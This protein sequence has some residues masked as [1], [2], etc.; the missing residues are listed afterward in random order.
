MRHFILYLLAMLIAISLGLEIVLR[1]FDPIGLWHIAYDNQQLSQAAQATHEGYLIAQGR[2]ELMGGTTT[3]LTGGAR[4]TPATNPLAPCKIAFI[5]DSYTQGSGVDDSST[6]VNQLA[7]LNPTIHVVNVGRSAYNAAQIVA[8]YQG[9][10]ADG[11][12]YL[13]I[14]NDWYRP[15][16]YA[17]MTENSFH[18][19]VLMLYIDYLRPSSDTSYADYWAGISDNNA[20]YRAA[21]LELTSDERVLSFA[22]DD[23]KYGTKAGRE[24]ASIVMIPAYK[25]YRLS[26]IDEHPNAEG[27]RLIAEAMNP[28][29]AE[30]VARVCP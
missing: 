24:Y 30:F 26:T 22:L 16:T 18:H 10:Q 15:V 3:F 1:L 6:F 25:E 27:H 28:Y 2:Y 20:E 29:I 17:K 9:I 14:G 23:G 5:G 19:S 21:M 7:M 4:F 13:Y 11:F 8:L 12:V